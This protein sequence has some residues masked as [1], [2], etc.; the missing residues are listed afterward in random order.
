MRDLSHIES[1]IFDLDNTLY[2]A[3]AAFFS[4]IVTRMT[5]FVSRYLDVPH[6]DAYAVQK[7]YL[8]EYGTT[9][10][11]L[12]AVHDMDPKDF[13]D[14]VHDVDHGLLT[15]DPALR[16]VLS[17][18]PGRR[19]IH[20]NGSKA[21]AETVATHLEIFDLFHGH[22]GVEDGDYVPKP[23]QQPYDMF[24]DTFDIDPRTSIFFEDSQRN[25]EVPKAMGMMTVLVVPDAQ[26]VS[27]A[28]FVD[29]VTDDLPGWLA[30]RR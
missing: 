17:E 1:W 27:A 18:L 20:T 5:G 6:A 14:F 7:T 22:F 30:A 26:Q 25:L 23:Q 28:P 11:G 8:N 29:H 15:P 2:P 3:N 21:H 10:S 13:L 12:M 19:L 24:K 4:Q 16:K 9:L